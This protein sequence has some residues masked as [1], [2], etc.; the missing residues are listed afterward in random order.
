VHINASN[1]TKIPEFELV[2]EVMARLMI[3][4]LKPQSKSSSFVH[5]Y[6]QFSIRYL[7]ERILAKEIKNL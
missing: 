4:K 7:M 3:L 5:A 1:L 2:S 6:T